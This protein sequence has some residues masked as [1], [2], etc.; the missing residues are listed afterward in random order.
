MS[1]TKHSWR[2]GK[3]YVVGHVT[4]LIPSL[5]DSKIPLLWTKYEEK[6]TAC[7]LTLAATQARVSTF[8]V[9][10]TFQKYLSIAKT[11]AKTVQ[12]MPTKFLPWWW[13]LYIAETKRYI[14]RN[15]RPPSLQV[16]MYHARQSYKPSPR[17]GLTA[18]TWQGINTLKYILKVH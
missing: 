15:I 7:R 10:R 12:T 13:C 17:E 1:F 2:S 14:H 8:A 3:C 16:A 5:H 9:E 11:A 6:K 18:L 4:I